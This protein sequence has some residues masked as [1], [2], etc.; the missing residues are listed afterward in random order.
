MIQDA[1]GGIRDLVNYVNQNSLNSCKLSQDIVGG[2]MGKLGSLVS[3]NCRA[4]SVDS[5]S[6][7]DPA[8]GAWYCHTAKTLSMKPI[9]CETP[10]NPK[11]RL[12]LPAVI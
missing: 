9:R 5:G 6:S 2:A 7:N 3:S 1:I 11:I 10:E 8:E 12:A 4:A